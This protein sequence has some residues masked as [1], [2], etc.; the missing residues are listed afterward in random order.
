MKSNLRC[1]TRPTSWQVHGKYESW[2]GAK[3]KNMEE[4]VMKPQSFLGL[5]RARR[6]LCVE[7]A[8]GFLVVVCLVSTPQRLVSISPSVVSEARRGGAYTT[9]DFP[10]AAVTASLGLNSFD[11][12]VGGYIDS[13][14]RRH[15]FLRT[16]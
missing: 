5:Q 4:D 6:A 9:V 10:D 2:Q 3:R 13:S 16:P 1:F 7:L 14:G 11:D 12:I 8:F 15:G